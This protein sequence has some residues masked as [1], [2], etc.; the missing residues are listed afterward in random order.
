MNNKFPLNRFEVA[1]ILRVHP[2]TI[3]REIRRG[4][5]KAFKVGKDYRI[6]KEAFE[7][8]VKSKKQSE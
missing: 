8:Y 6:D 7:E 3:Y 2:L 5:L 1:A 4:K